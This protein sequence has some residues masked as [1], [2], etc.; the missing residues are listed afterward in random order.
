[1]RIEEHS[2]T[3]MTQSK[4]G[5]GTLAGWGA[6]LAGVAAVIRLL[7]QT[8]PPPIQTPAIQTPP[9]PLNIAGNWLMNANNFTF[10]LEIEQDGNKISG[11]MTEIENE[12]SRTNIQGNI[13]ENMESNLSRSQNF[14]KV[15]SV[16]CFSDRDSDIESLAESA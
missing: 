13:Q 16:N 4:L 9:E 5:F 11:T 12:S 14:L 2:P 1:M 8:P 10:N 15:L 7:V 6:F 3:A